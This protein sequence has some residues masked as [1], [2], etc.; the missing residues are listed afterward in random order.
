MQY[1]KIGHLKIPCE[2]RSEGNK[3]ILKIFGFKLPFYEYK[4]SCGQ[5]YYKI[6]GVKLKSDL[7][8]KTEMSGKIK[9]LGKWQKKFSWKN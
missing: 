3:K 7:I 2:V 5:K 9:I 8:F 1:I 6:L 4:D